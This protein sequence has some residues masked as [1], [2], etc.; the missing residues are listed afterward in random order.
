MKSTSNK[1]YLQTKAIFKKSIA[2]ALIEKGH[3]LLNVKPQY[4]NTNHYV[5][6]FERTESFLKDFLEIVSS[7][8]AVS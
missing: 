5:Y 8:K 3:T 2:M 6:I 1:L 7:E 4:Q